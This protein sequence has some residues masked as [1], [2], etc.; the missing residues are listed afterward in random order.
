[1]TGADG[2]QGY[3][4]PPY[5]APLWPTRVKVHQCMAPHVNKA[6]HLCD[7]A[8]MWSA[9]YD[10]ARRSRAL[11]GYLAAHYHLPALFVRRGMGHLLRYVS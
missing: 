9:V 8:V 11:T 1:M 10:R 7:N 2:P 3:S 6:G 5:A 4:V